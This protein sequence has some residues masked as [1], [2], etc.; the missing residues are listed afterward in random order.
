MK[1]AL[2]QLKSITGSI[3]AVHR[4]KTIYGFSAEYSFNID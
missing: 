1:I 4:T 3:D 2:A